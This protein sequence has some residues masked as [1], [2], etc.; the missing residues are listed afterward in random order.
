MWADLD[1]EDDEPGLWTALLYLVGFDAEK[2]EFEEFGD[3]AL[4][5]ATHYYLPD[6]TWSAL[7]SFWGN[8]VNL[9]LEGGT[10]EQL[11][12]FLDM[13]FEYA[14]V[15]GMSTLVLTCEEEQTDP[16]AVTH[17]D[18]DLRHRII[19]LPDPELH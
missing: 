4:H 13:I 17:I 3:L 5:L 10:L 9:P 7:L 1:N 18:V 16:R 19:P 15:Q 2:V 14:D 11:C 8:R 6:A 12:M